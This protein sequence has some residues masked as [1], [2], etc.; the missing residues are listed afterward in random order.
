MAY[1]CDLTNELGITMQLNATS[2][3]EG[4]WLCD[5]T[6]GDKSRCTISTLMSLVSH[7]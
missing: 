7:A 1:A 6:G 4:K 5:Q 2:S 3:G